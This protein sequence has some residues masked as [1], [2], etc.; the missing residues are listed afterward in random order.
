MEKLEIETQLS[1]PQYLKLS[2]VLFYK[3][4][5]IV[6]MTLIGLFL[7]IISVR[8]ILVFDGGTEGIYKPLGFGI[9]M[10]IVFPLTV[11]WSAR[12]NFSNKAMFTEKMIYSFDQEQIHILGESFNSSM[13]WSKI[14]KVEELNEWILIY[15]SKA[16]ANLIPK[17]AF[18]DSEFQQF[19]QII[20]QL[21]DLKKKMK[22][23]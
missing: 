19:Q 3:K 18:S 12:R 1:F 22:K 11:Y 9:L 20:A 13:S 7:L 8:N 4:T 23:A 5:L 6:I 10:V 17:D 21:P 14:F 2:Y 16:V 15:Q